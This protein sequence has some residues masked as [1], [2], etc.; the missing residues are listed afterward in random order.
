MEVGN[1]VEF[2]CNKTILVTGTTGFL[3]KVLLEKI[4][5]IQPNVKKLYLLIRIKDTK[6]SLERLHDQIIGKELFRVLRERHGAEFDSFISEKVAPIDGDTS[7]VNLGL[8]DKSEIYK[9]IDVIIH[10]AAVTKFQERYDL[11]LGINTLGARNVLQYAKTCPKLQVLVHVSTAYVCREKAG[12]I[13]ETPCKMGE[14]L[15]G[16][17]IDVEKKLANETLNGLTSKGASTKQIRDTMKSLGQKRADVYGCANTY[18]F[19]KVMAEMLIWEHKGDLPVVIVRPTMICST[20][21]EPFPGWIEGVGS[22]GT[23]SIL[24]GKGLINFL[25]ADGNSVIDL[26]PVDMVVNSIIS[27]M[28]ANAN[29]PC[30]TIYQVGSS[31]RNPLTVSKLVDINYRYFNKNPWIDGQGVP[32]KIKKG[33]LVKDRLHFLM[34]SVQPIPKLMVLKLVDIALCRYFKL[35]QDKLEM[36]LKVAV[37]MA[38]IFSHYLLFAGI[39]DDEN[40]EKLRTTIK[41]IDEE[42]FNF[43]PKSIDWEDYLFNHHIPA[44]VNYLF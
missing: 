41:R 26:I 20:Y 16:I 40:T 10:S 29:K 25:Y 24:Y 23:L 13:L 37:K 11:A 30:L 27:G 39:F 28:V 1:E 42:G 17:D 9:E 7:L 22:T 19:T 5:R 32:V 36:Q 18:V 12:L 35:N 15:S 3:G 43:D 44:I 14:T 38:M 8:K 2:L 33:K 6:S 21:K 4:L 31:L 34:L